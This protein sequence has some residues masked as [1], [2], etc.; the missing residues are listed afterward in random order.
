M[1][2]GLFRLFTLQMGQTWRIGSAG[3]YAQ[4]GYPAA[5]YTL[6]ILREH[7]VDLSAHR[8]RLITADL[9][10][11]F[12]LALTMEQG[13]KEALLAAFPNRIGKIYLLSEMTGKF[14]DI[15]DPIGREYLDYLDTAREIKGIFSSGFDRI[16]TLAE[17]D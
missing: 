14:R 15:V 4:P 2:E 12:Q 8:S 11:Q 6:E 16:A 17:D 3:V 10:K 7:G 9:I 13:H 5:E 1:A